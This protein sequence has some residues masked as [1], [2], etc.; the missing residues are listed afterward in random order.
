LNVPETK[1]THLNNGLTVATHHCPT[2]TATV[3]LWIKAG[4]RSENE[5]NNGTAHF[6]EH[7]AFKVL[8]LP[9]TSPNVSKTRI[10]KGVSTKNTTSARTS[11]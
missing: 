7:M 1:V 5:K 3:G 4:S 10:S 8:A 9:V 2:E 11:D 6:L